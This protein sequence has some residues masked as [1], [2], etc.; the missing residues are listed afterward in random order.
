MHNIPKPQKNVPA[1]N[2]HLKV[3]GFWDDCDISSR[4]YLEL[5]FLLVSIILSL[6]LHFTIAAVCV[7]APRNSS[8]L[9]TVT[10]LMPLLLHMFGSA[11][12]C[13]VCGILHLWQGSCLPCRG[14]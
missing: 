5:C 12:S 3:A 10:C 13:G 2:C 4:V 8:S 11:L 6:H 1:N 7:I 9:T 14:D